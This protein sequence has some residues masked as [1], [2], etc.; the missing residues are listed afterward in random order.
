MKHLCLL[1]PA[2]GLLGL[3]ASTLAAQQSNDGEVTFSRDV[4]PIL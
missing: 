2:V 4:A 3:G 1:L